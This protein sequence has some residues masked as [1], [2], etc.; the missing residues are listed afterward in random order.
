MLDK[1]QKERKQIIKEVVL[2]KCAI[3]EKLGQRKLTPSDF[4]EIDEELAAHNICLT[5]EEHDIL[6]F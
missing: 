5:E 1:N 3:R 6:G 4:E 2:A